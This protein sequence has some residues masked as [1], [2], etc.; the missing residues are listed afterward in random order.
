MAKKKNNDVLMWVIFAVVL[1]LL[2]KL[3][4]S[5]PTNNPQ[6]NQFFLD[7]E[8]SATSLGENL[9]NGQAFPDTETPSPVTPTANLCSII[10]PYVFVFDA[11]NMC[12][13][14]GG[15]WVCTTTDIGCYNL[16]SPVVD[17]SLGV[18]QTALSQCRGKGATATC[19]TQNVNCKY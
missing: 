16:R 17:C 4:W 11:Q 10:T 15:T 14:G 13:L 18:V 12:N 9:G 19:N 6:T 3:D 2:F 7:K 8:K 1:I 5:T